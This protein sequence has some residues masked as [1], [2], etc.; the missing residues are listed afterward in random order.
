MA[1]SGTLPE[2]EQHSRILV[3]LIFVGGLYYARDRR[4]VTQTKVEFV[5][6]LDS[7]R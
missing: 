3:W 5:H 6:D 4:F 2:A 7:H 1:V